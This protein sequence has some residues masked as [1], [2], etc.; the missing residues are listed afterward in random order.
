MQRRSLLGAMAA[1]AAAPLTLRLAQLAAQPVQPPLSAY[2]SVALPV[3][4]R[5][6]LDEKLGQMAQ[7]EL[8]QIKDGDIER[9]ALGSVLSGGNADPAGGNGFADWTD[10]VEHAIRSSLATRLKIPIL[11]G[12]DAVHG[13]SNVRGAVIFPH[14]I[15]LGCTRDPELVEEIGRV[16]AVEVRAT[17]IQWTFAPC[18]AVP[19]DIRWGRTYEGYGEDSALVSELGAA[20]IRGLQ[21]GYLARIGRSIRHTPRWMAAFAVL[22]GAR[23][24]R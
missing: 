23:S 24:M 5:M 13:H 18:V 8:G 14:N 3:L 15:G 1:G 17:G 21:R 20:A 7:G 2:D 16:T 19:R 10:A 22:V 11:Y 6:S 4:E 12:I 9:L